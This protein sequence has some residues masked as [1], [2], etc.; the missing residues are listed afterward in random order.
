MWNIAQTLCIEYKIIFF[1]FMENIV[2]NK[3]IYLKL[4]YIRIKLN[5]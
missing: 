2:K 3:N 5:T 4:F 1:V